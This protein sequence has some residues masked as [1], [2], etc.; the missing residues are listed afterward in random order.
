MTQFAEQG[1]NILVGTPGRLTEF[2]F[3]SEAGAP[4]TGKKAESAKKMNKKATKG[5]G[6]NLKELEMLILDEADRFAGSVRM[7]LSCRVR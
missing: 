3:G 7:S 6:A 2:L 1:S 5:S 4:S